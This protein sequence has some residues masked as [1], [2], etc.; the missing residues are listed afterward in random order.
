MVRLFLLTILLLHPF[1]GLLAQSAGFSIRRSQ[2]TGKVY[3][4]VARIVVRND[5]TTPGTFRLPA[6]F[7]PSRGIFQSYLIPFATELVIGPGDEATIDLYGYCMDPFQKAVPSGRSLA[8]HTEWIFGSAD[9]RISELIDPV[10]GGLT[11]PCLPAAVPGSNVNRF[12]VHDHVPLLISMIAVIHDHALAMQSLPQGIPLSEMV[13]HAVWRMLAALGRDNWTYQDAVNYWHQLPGV[14]VDTRLNL[15]YVMGTS[16]IWEGAEVLLNEGLCE[17]LSSLPMPGAMI[18]DSRLLVFGIAETITVDRTTASRLPAP[19]QPP[20]PPVPPGQSCTPRYE[21]LAE[22]LMD[23][24]L[25]EYSVGEFKLKHAVP[26]ALVAEGADADQIRFWCETADGCP[27]TNSIRTEGLT[28]RVRFRWEHADGPGNFLIGRTDT[29]R[30][31]DDK[32]VLWQPPDLFGAIRSRDTTTVTRLR[33]FILDD[34]PGQPQ[35]QPVERLITIT[36]VRDSTMAFDSL[37]VTVR[38][39][40]F[41]RYSMPDP[42]LEVGTC[43]TNPLAWDRKDDLKLRLVKG[44]DD[45]IFPEEKTILR[46]RDK[47]DPDDLVLSCST[48]CKT[49]PLT[50]TLEDEV[51]YQWKLLGSMKESGYFMKGEGIIGAMAWGRE[52]IYLAPKLSKDDLR[53]E[54]LIEVRAYNPPGS[55]HDIYRS[56][57]LAKAIDAVIIDTLR[58]Y[59]DCDP[60]RKRPSAIVVIGWRDEFKDHDH[61]WIVETLRDVSSVVALTIPPD[62]CE[63]KLNSE[64][65]GD[66]TTGLGVWYVN[67]R[68]HDFN[69]QTDDGYINQT[70]CFSQGSYW[71]LF[72]IGIIIDDGFI[73]VPSKKDVEDFAKFTEDII[74]AI[75]I[76][77]L[78]PRLARM[79]YEGRYESAMS[80][81]LS[82]FMLS[83]IGT[84]DV[85]DT[86]P[87]FN[88]M[89]DDY[90]RENPGATRA[91]AIAALK[92]EIPLYKKGWQNNHFVKKYEIG[93]IYSWWIVL[94]HPANCMDNC[95]VAIDHFTW[96]SLGDTD[97]YYKRT[98]TVSTVTYPNMQPHHHSY[99]FSHENK[100][101]DFD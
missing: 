41:S 78:Y 39:D 6:C 88:R 45:L 90:M 18:N 20:T 95:P 24:G 86:D 2:G 80:E 5:L 101:A 1:A 57:E 3:G 40:V 47:R 32:V 61:P 25:N 28:S 29:S 22:P 71:M 62:D 11:W 42:T 53:R 82:T 73:S 64:F 38:G 84:G 4:N 30:E 63:P 65:E 43:L 17:Q 87:F 50:L 98:S 94:S 15:D 66:K 68:L 14:S 91:E 52:V 12:N 96:S 27:E 100:G 31:S 48:A 74:E 99:S 55:Q 97:H 60:G 76:A 72:D 33:L 83:F 75:T 58:I 9:D 8:A 81:E 19:P 21:L 26:V 89:I 70:F 44:Y 46:A 37:R 34:L 16:L 77:S 92:K 59:I 54:V 7:I 23:G 79:V 10:A 36:C 51:V 13:Q 49:G 56:P 69:P 85:P 93:L 67:P 35:D